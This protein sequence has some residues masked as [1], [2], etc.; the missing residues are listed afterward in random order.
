MFLHFIHVLI[1]LAFLV[2]DMTDLQLSEYYIIIRMQ[3]EDFHIASL[4]LGSDT[5]LPSDEYLRIGLS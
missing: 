5:I 4:P 2:A 1:P 3:D